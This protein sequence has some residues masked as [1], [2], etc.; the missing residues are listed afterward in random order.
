MSFD[1]FNPDNTLWHDN[2]Q[3]ETTAYCGVL[4]FLALGARICRYVNY[5]EGYD[6]TMIPPPIGTVIQVDAAPAASQGQAN[7]YMSGF[8]F[9]VGGTVNV[10]GVGLSAG[11]TWTNTVVT[12]VPPLQLSAG[13]TGNEGAFWQFRYCTGG[14]EPDGS[15]T[16]HVQ[17]S[18]G[19][20]NR[21]GDTS[22]TNPQLGQTPGGKFSDAV[23]SVHWEAGPDTRTNATT[24]DIN[25]AF[26]VHL[27][28]TTAHLSGYYNSDPVQACNF[29][30]CA[31]TSES[32][33]SQEI[34]SFTFEVP[35]PS[36]TCQ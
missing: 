19:C 28:T 10:S 20:R 9:N 29:F 5:P 35:F 17:T 8:S 18:T 6:L 31:C 26:N 34:S 2:G 16:N 25:V 33:V 13:N 32:E 22:G 4:P 24:F 14:Q 1:P 23:Q 15:C 27:T 12:T 3:D 36:T 7:T 30:N 11:A 21:L